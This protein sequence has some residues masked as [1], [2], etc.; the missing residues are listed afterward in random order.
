MKQFRALLRHWFS[1][2]GRIGR[3]DYNSINV[4]ALML[5]LAA[6]MVFVAPLFTM[7]ITGHI[8]FASIP[9]GWNAWIAG[10]LMGM[11]LS[12]AV[13]SAVRR[14][15]DFGWSG[16]WLAL[17]VSPLREFALFASLLGIGILSFIRGQREQNAYGSEA[18]PDQLV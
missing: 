8:T 10:V 13:S 3:G 5:V 7:E 6:N 9:L 15:H 17:M 14:L 2:N 11:G 1:F 4:V 12:M 16:W 18:S